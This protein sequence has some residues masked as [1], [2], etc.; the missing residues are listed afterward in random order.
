MKHTLESKFVHKG[1][2]R[3]TRTIHG[4]SVATI[5]EAR[6]HGLHVDATTLDQLKECAM[7]Y[8]GGVK[9]KADHGSGVL[10]TVGFLK[11]F[12]LDGNQLRADFEIFASEK[13][14][15]KLFDMAEKIPDT[16]GL[17]VNFAGEDQK[18]GS[19]TFARCSE[20]FS[21]DIVTEPAA[22]KHGLFSAKDEDPSVKKMASL[23]EAVVGA[24]RGFGL[25]ASRFALKQF[26]GPGSGPRKGGG[27]SK[28]AHEMLKS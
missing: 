4:V 5:G 21:A 2:D 24:T 13:D 14:G 8:G 12:Q 28:D 20:L 16:F 9:V 18:V 11:N 23:G 26:G 27:S 1:I 19:L 22:N 3:G 15:E 7:K 10:S 17:S 25:A 6:G